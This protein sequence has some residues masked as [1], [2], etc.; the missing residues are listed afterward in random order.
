MEIV[1]DLFVFKLLV[2]FLGFS[3]A[4]WIGVW[5]LDGDRPKTRTITRELTPEEYHEVA[6]RKRARVQYLDAEIALRLKQ[7]ELDDATKFIKD[8]K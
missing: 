3:A 4:V 1:I 5:M 2:V 8:R 7:A 6:A